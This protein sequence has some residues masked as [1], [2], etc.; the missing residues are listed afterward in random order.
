MANM[1]E[2]PRRGSREKKVFGAGHC[3][4]QGDRKKKERGG[5]KVKDR[6]KRWGGHIAR[7]ERCR[8]P[9]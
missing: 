5:R 9:E 2:G 1:M 7:S 3:A 6:K 8:G 4:F